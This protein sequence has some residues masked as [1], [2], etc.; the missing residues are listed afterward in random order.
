VPTIV[1]GV[2]RPDAETQIISCASCPTNNITPLV[3]I[4]DRRFGVEKALL[5][6]VHAYTATAEALTAAWAKMG[7]SRLRERSRGQANRQPAPTVDSV[8]PN[9]APTALAR[10][11]DQAAGRV[12]VVVLQRREGVRG[13][14]EQ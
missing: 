11:G 10:V 8:V 12:T 6:T 13:A 5:T 4:L 2:N 14:E 7:A 3:E 1:H 9:T